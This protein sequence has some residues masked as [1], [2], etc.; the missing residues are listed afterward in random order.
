MERSIQPE[1]LKSEFAGKFILD[2]RRSA[3]RDATSE[4]I[5]TAEWKD[6]ERL[7]EWADTLPKE[8]DIILYCVRGGSVSNSVV[9]A[10]QAKGFRARFIEGAAG[11]RSRGPNGDATAEAAISARP[12]ASLAPATGSHL[13]S[14]GTASPFAGGLEVWKAAG[15]VVIGK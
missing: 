3:D 12:T 15:G 9:D 6:P 14:E 2:V 5:P 11:A 1:I 10:L 4:Q 13:P 7:A 8:G